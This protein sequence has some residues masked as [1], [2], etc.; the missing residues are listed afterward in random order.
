MIN[1]TIIPVLKSIKD[2]EKAIEYS[3]EY[4]IIMDIHISQLAHCIK[5]IKSYGKKVLIHLELIKGLSSDAYGVEFVINELD[6]DG[7]ITVKSSVI[8]KVKK[9]GR[10]AIQR[11]FIIDTLSYQKSLDLIKVSKPDY[12]EM[13]PGCIFKMIKRVKAD[14]KVNVIAGGLIETEDEYKMAINSGASAITT[15]KELLLKLIKI[16]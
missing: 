8:E 6:V 14:L 1:Q 7:I 13:L 4:V 2:C 11:I 10:I 12:I 16:K 5:L 9:L 15:S 3:A